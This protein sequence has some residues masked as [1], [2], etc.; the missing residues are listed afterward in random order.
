VHVRAC[1]SSL[2]PHTLADIPYSFP[3]YIL[4]HLPQP[5]NASAV[6]TGAEIP[7]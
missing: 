4:P 5:K 6:F 2:R 3:D 1:V 7:V